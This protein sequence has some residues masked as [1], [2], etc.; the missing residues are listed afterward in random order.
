MTQPPHRS[1]PP[2][3]PARPASLHPARRASDRQQTAT[4]RAMHAAVDR[5]LDVWPQALLDALEAAYP[6]GGGGRSAKGDH[7]D[8][9]AGMAGFPEPARGWLSD[10]E[11][12]RRRL[13]QLA[14]D[15]ARLWPMKAK[16]GMVVDG[17]T[18][19]RRGNDV[20]MCGLCRQPAPSDGRDGN[21]RP[22]VHKVPVGD[23]HVMLHRSPCY[24]RVWRQAKASGQT[25]SVWWRWNHPA[26]VGSVSSSANANDGSGAG[27]AAN[28]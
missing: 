22:L 15:A 12:V 6:S 4:R 18:V 27:R 24:D 20:E 10:L 19:G 21:G 11:D 1:G 25:I 13:Y 16:L 7:A 2:A 17:V 8:P 3:G 14:D 23:G 28:A 9:T 5:A 26:G